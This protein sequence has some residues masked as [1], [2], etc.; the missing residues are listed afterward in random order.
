MGN[1]G[2]YLKLKW[3]MPIALYPE[4]LGTQVA[5]LIKYECVSCKL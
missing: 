4:G 5:I 1:L 3:K 2:K